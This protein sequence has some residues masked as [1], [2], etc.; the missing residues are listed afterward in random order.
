IYILTQIALLGALY[1]NIIFNTPETFQKEVVNSFMWIGA[2]AILLI[3]IL[4]IRSLISA[5]E[6]ETLH[7]ANEAY[8]N[9]VN[10]L[11]I[12]FRAQRHDFSNHIQ[13]VNS[14]IALKKY[15]QANKYLKELVKETADINTVLRVNNPVIAA[16]LRVKL[17]QAEQ[18]CITLD[19]IITN[20]FSKIPL[21]SF[22]IV[23]LLGNL[24]DNAIE[25]TE[26]L[27]NE[28]RV[29]KLK[30]SWM[31]K[32]CYISVENPCNLLNANITDKVFDSGFST[33]HDHSGIGLVVC[34]K[35]IEKYTGTIKAS[36]PYGKNFIVE[37]R[38]P[39]KE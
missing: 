24:L 9:Q 13:T 1:L 29:I 6:K 8:L 12:T 34:K 15:D 18:K 36:C 21:K 37:A 38:I 14:L 33:K 23:K 17:A 4:L 19:L 27:P 39:C 10:E 25:A 11:F 5:V 31:E 3:D 35:I 2:I 7:E 16:L 26:V 32:Q 20:D 30:L 28:D 22:E